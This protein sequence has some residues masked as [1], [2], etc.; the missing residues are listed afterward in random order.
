MHVSGYALIYL[1]LSDLIEKVMCAECGH[2][3]LTAAGLIS[4]IEVDCHGEAG[5]NARL[6][7]EEATMFFECFLVDCEGKYTFSHVL[8][9]VPNT[10]KLRYFSRRLNIQQNTIIIT[11]YQF[12]KIL[13]IFCVHNHQKCRIIVVIIRYK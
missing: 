9:L 10:N 12:F 5:S 11:V 13:I 3:P 7:S 2:K 8:N 1:F 4:L 6:Q